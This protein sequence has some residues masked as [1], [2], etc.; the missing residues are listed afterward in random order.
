M[1]THLKIPT[2]HYLL[3][4]HVSVGLKYFNPIAIRHHGVVRM[5]NNQKDEHDHDMRVK[6]P[7]LCPGSAFCNFKLQED[8]TTGR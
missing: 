6:V 3:N 4:K 7:Q 1:D 8:E 2:L 5:F